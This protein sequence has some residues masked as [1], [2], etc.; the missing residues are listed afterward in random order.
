MIHITD[1]NLTVNIGNQENLLI[2]MQHILEWM[3][4][5]FVTQPDSIVYENLAVLISRPKL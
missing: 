4:F 3:A 1:K 5:I 2:A